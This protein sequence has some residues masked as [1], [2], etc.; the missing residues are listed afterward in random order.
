MISPIAAVGGAQSGTSTTRI[1]SPPTAVAIKHAAALGLKNF[2]VLCCHV[3]TPPAM[4]AILN[5][6]ER[7]AIEGFVGPDGIATFGLLLQREDVGADLGEGAELGR[8]VE[9]AVDADV[10]LHQAPAG[11]PSSA[12]DAA[13]DIRSAKLA[14]CEPA[15]RL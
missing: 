2:S 3:L 5:A 1:T 8:L 14:D 10:A 13:F 4:M 12:R 7:I 11:R 6:P 15:P 9:V